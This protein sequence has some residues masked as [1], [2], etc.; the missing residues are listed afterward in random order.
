MQSKYCQKLLTLVDELNQSPHEI[1]HFIF[2]L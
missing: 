2:S 1:L